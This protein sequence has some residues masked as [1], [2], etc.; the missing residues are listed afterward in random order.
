MMG[1]VAAIHTVH[2]V[3][4]PSICD[5]VCGERERERER[6]RGRDEWRGKLGEREGDRGT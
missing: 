5:L 3:H 1:E 2:T 6:E 4:L